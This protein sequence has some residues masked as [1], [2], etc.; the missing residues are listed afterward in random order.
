MVVLMVTGWVPNAL[1]ALIAC[2]LLGLT[3]CITLDSAYKSIQW[4]SLLLI[5]GL[6]PFS[7]AL[8]KTGGVDLVAQGL[9]H[10]FGGA[11]PRLLLAALFSFTAITSMFVS[12]T[13]TALLMAPI[14]L[15]VAGAL[16]ASPYPFVMTVALAASAA[17]MTPVSSP[18][19]TLV[20]VPG[21]YRFGDFVRIGVPFTIIVLVLTVL[22]VPW[23]L[24]LKP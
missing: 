24:P 4:P 22:L 12:N 17:F 14:A 6:M 11:E 5:V 23:L 3:R 7:T 2:L 1:A 10:V 16:D 9:V 8:Q 13:A 15:R 20:L 19:N 21:K 18:V